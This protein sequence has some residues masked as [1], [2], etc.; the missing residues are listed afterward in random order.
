MAML[1]A[2]LCC[3]L[4]VFSQGEEKLSAW[5]SPNKLECSKIKKLIAGGKQRRDAKETLGSAGCL[6]HISPHIPHRMVRSGKSFELL[7]VF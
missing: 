1:W 6:S 4:V 3:Q 2:M 5:L 7:P